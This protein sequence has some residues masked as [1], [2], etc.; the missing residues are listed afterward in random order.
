MSFN[1]IETNQIKF[2]K[3]LA[4]NT[5]VNHSRTEVKIKNGMAVICKFMRRQVLEHAYHKYE[6][7]NQKILSS[8][9]TMQMLEGM[10]Q[11]QTKKLSKLQYTLKKL[12]AGEQIE[13][14][15]SPEKFGDTFDNKDLD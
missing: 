6:E 4:G 11:S 5:E 10:S 1:D 15:I 9:I 12:D 14:L 7:T 13:D 3:L 2:K 8:K